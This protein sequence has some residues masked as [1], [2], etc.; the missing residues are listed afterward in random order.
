M[1]IGFDAG[2]GRTLSYFRT[3]S[4]PL[5]VCVPGGPGMDPEAYFAALELP[6]HELLVF[7][8]RGTGGSTPPGFA[9][10]YEIAGYVE[11]LD[12]LYEHL[13]TGPLTLYG[14]SHGGCVALAYATRRPE[15]VAR[16]IVANGPPRIDD[17]YSAA[18]AEVRG[19][20]AERL[21]DGAERL[22]AADRADE[23]L[24]GDLDEVERRRQFRAV[25]AR[26]TARTG[27]AET[28][29]LDRLCAAPMNWDGVGVMYAEFSGGL[30][31]LA[32]ADRVT[33]PAL[34][35]A[36]ELDVTVPAASMRQVAEALP[37]ARYVEFPEVGHFPDVEA[38][39][40]FRAAVLEFLASAA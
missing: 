14:N 27:P 21:A 10:G 16:L 18:A 36:G 5:V 3:G 13:D 2:E 8:P 25:M 33:A 29:Y 39:E 37:E 20:F 15:R 23:A 17:A 9:E 19:R 7:A 26:Y 32:E 34:V 40:E 28:A 22:D 4:G 1:Y 38:P 12:S 30:D 35:I 31:L 11:D 24:E 6:G